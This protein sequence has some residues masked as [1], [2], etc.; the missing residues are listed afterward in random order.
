MGLLE[1]F[2]SGKYNLALFAIVFFFIFHQY[3]DKKKEPM[4]NLDVTPQLKEAIKQVYMADVDAIRNL[5]EVASKLQTGGL[6]I[7]GFLKTGPSQWDKY[8]IFGGK[9]RD[10]A[11][12]Q[13]QVHATDGN[14]H[15]DSANGKT[16]FINFY[17]KTPTRIEGSLDVI[18]ATNITGAFNLLPRG[19]IVAWTGANAPAGWAICNGQ[20]GT[21]DLRN[22]F[23]AGAGGQYQV[24]ATG[25]AD[26]VALNVAQMPS[27]VHSG[28][29]YA[30]DCR[31]V[32]ASGKGGCWMSGP[33]A[34]KNTDAS[35]G[36]QAHENRPPFYALAYIMKL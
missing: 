12:G 21:P 5:S 9:N 20:N 26:V 24:G 35:G 3:W 11:G 18:G 32:R 27:H 25:G 34:W 17:T 30:V 4:A 6:T 31:D 7:P 16:T 22:R 33:P 8:T 28:V 15:L 13:A 36:N 1:D 14:L 2:N 29:G 19:I 10:A 23:I